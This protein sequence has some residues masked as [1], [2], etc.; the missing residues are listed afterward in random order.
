M[1]TNLKNFLKTSYHKKKY[2]LVEFLIF[3]FKTF[4]GFSKM[5]K[6]NVQIWIFQK[7]V[8]IFEKL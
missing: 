2:G 6:K 5:D 4:F 1:V 8:G 3:F 7:N